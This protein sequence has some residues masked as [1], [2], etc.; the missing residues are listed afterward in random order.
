MTKSRDFVGNYDSIRALLRDMFFYGC[1]TVD[2]FEEKGVSP[3]KYVKDKRKLLGI[4]RRKHI[5]SRTI[6]G[7]QALHFTSDMFDTAYNFL[8]DTYMMKS[9]VE[10]DVK[11]AI[12]VL[13]ILSTADSP[14]TQSEITDRMAA[15]DTEVPSAVTMYRILTEQVEVGILYADASGHSHIYGVSEDIFAGL[16]EQEFMGLMQATDFMRNISYPST[17][18]NLLFDTLLRYRRSAGITTGYSSP[19]LFKHNH[20]GH[21]LDDEVLWEVLLA[22]HSRESLT[23]EYGKGSYSCVIP[24]KVIMDELYGRRYLFAVETVE[25]RARLFRLDKI[26][27]VT[28]EHHDAA[29]QEK[30][31]Q[32]YQSL[33]RHSFTGACAMKNEFLFEVS[34]LVQESVLENV[35]LRLPEASVALVEEGRYLVTTLVNDPIELKPWLRRYTGSVVVQKDDTH[36]LAEQMEAELKEWVKLYEDI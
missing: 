5:K 28:R 7:K 2:D 26:Y 4:I 34:L 10:N 23:F 12:K 24:I 13:Q 35:R 3:S 9:F 21:V 29:D 27:S 32:L 30:L 15:Y 33:M 22:I 31:E 8:Y 36:D 20:F 25:S 16:S 1:L 18:G 6:R 19:F 17:C 14:L 11:S